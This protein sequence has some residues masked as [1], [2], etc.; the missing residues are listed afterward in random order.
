MPVTNT[1]KGLEE[2]ELYSSGINYTKRRPYK[3][4]SSI[5]LNYCPNPVILFDSALRVTDFNAAMEQYTFFSR[6]RALGQAI[7]QIC[8]FCSFPEAEKL[9]KKVTKGKSVHLP[10]RE[11]HQFK[12]GTSN[13]SIDIEPVYNE[14]GIISGGALIAK[15]AEKTTKVNLSTETSFLLSEAELLAG[16]GTWEWNTITNEINWSDNLYRIYGMEP[17][18]KE[19]DLE[20]FLK[21]IYPQDLVIVNEFIDHLI[22]EKNPVAYEH[23]IIRKD[24]SIRF[25]SGK[26]KPYFDEKGNLIK[27]T[28]CTVD[29]TER[30]E[31]QAL[32]E[33]EKDFSENI[34]NNSTYGIIAFDTGLKFTAWNKTMEK[35]TGIRRKI[36]LGKTIWQ[37][38]PGLKNLPNAELFR[39]VLEGKKVLLNERASDDGAWYYETN[40]VPLKN[41]SGHILGGLILINDITARKNAEQKLKQKNKEL[42]QSNKELERFA[43]VISHDLKEPLRMITSYTQLFTR[44]Y[45]SLLD[46]DAKEII[47]Y[48][49]DGVQRIQLLIDDLIEYN[50]LGSQIIELKPVKTGPVLENVL[51]DLKKEIDESQAIITYDP[52]PEIKC[53]IKQ[54]DRLFYN[55]I[56]NAIKFHGSNPLQ[57]HISAMKKD[58]KWIFSIKDNG[59]GIDEKYKERIFILFQRLHGR[60]A[61]S[62]TGIGLAICKKI[63]ELHNGEIWFESTPGK[64]TTFFF[65][66]PE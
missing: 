41:K 30:K 31:A 18:E 17:Q 46:K 13:F 33:A 52:L 61:Y 54:L 60:D 15:P 27:V 34:V 14:A 39:E 36:A 62:G 51:K 32:L 19:I 44:K 5:L 57:I 3:G 42:A 25:I 8:E 6:P 24:G 40:M 35:L 20:L 12:D 45:Q 7:T 37:L 9:I 47:K 53:N 26:S 28:G 50:S 65:S 56:D 2:E 66:F 4:L 59:I 49:L 58:K 21:S 11:Y 22:R 63:T 48:A 23:R 38:F 10:A 1:K 29:I 64:G 43:D 55:L 16:Y